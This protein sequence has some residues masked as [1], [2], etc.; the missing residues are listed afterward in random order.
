MLAL[1]VGHSAFGEAVGREG[2]F[3]LIQQWLTRM[4]RAL[5]CES[6]SRGGCSSLAG[7]CVPSVVSY[8]HGGLEQLTR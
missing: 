6:P 4:G 2:Q 7:G 1:G 3:V 5:R 8:Q